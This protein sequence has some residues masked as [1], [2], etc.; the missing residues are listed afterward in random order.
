MFLPKSWDTQLVEKKVAKTE[1]DL[2]SLAW[3]P[4]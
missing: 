3:N 2:L 1:S 4:W